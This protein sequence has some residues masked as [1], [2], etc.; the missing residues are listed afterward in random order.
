MASVINKGNDKYMVRVFLG[1]DEKG[2]V[3]FHNKTIKGKREAQAYLAK[4]TNQKNEGIISDSGK[5]TVKE[6]MEI[7]LETV[8]KNRVRV[9]AYLDY[10][11]R[12][13]LYITPVVGEI[14]LDKLKP[15]QIQVLYNDMLERNL[16]PRTVRYTQPY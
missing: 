3:K 10:K 16:S 4:M 8:V 15:E 12:T 9:K 13:R 14:R 7:W 6:H 11:D 1:R 2:K 5:V